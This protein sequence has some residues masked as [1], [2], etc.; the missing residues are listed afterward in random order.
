M[1]RLPLR[2]LLLAACACGLA[3]PLLAQDGTPPAPATPPAAPAG[4]DPR[5]QYDVTYYRLDLRVFPAKKQIA[6]I[7]VT[8]ATAKVEGLARVVLDLHRK[9]TVDGV[10]EVPL[11]CGDA[12]AIPLGEALAFA[13]DGDLLAI[14]LRA[15]PAAGAAFAVAVRYHGEPMVEGEPR[16]A[17]TGFHWRETPDGRPWINTSCQG[18]G[19]HTWWPCKASFFFPDDKPDHMDLNV[20]VPGDLVAACNGVLREAEPADHPEGRGRLFRW[21]HPYPCC[22]YAIALNVA[23]YVELR[24]EIPLPEI[25]KPLQL[26]YYVLPQDVAKAKKQFAE[27]PEMLRVFGE[28]FGPFPFPDAKYGLVQTN[29]WGMEHSTIVAYG[30]SFPAAV[31]KNKDRYASRN[32]WFDYILIH[33]SAHEWWGNAVSCVDWGDFWIHEGFGTYAEVIW[34]EHRHGTAEMHKYA[35]HLARMVDDRTPIWQARHAT[36]KEAYTG[37]LYYKGACVLHQL[38][39]VM[40]DEPFLRAIKRFNLEFRYKNAT[41]TDFRKICEAECGQPLEW[42]FEQWVYGIGRPDIQCRV[43]EA[44]GGAAVVATCG[45]NSDVKF[46]WPIAIDVKRGAGA[47]ETARVFIEPGENRF[48]VVD[49]KPGDVTVRGLDWLVLQESERPKRGGEGGRK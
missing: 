43:E 36:G 40:G 1:P 8:Q 21:R 14:T 33:E 31:P 44:E 24:G 46:R 41:T 10:H 37:N 35:R 28:K 48:P 2:F 47:P 42:Y 34:V 27:V 45:S 16:T 19:A 15:A 29:Y 26:R 23:P 49:A 12:P 5:Q 39:G 13:R 20:S 17:F 38:R 4:S 6:G 25:E 3:A 30:S 7:G 18:I 11:D 9:L 22:T 32:Q